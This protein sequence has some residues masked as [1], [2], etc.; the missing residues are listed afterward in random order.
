MVGI[1]HS[2][3]DPDI[4]NDKI[5]P[6]VR[7]DT[8]TFFRVEWSG[9]VTPLAQICGDLPACQ[10]TLDNMC[11]CDVDV[12]ETQVFVAVPNRDDVLRM[13]H[14]GAFEPSGAATGSLNGV[15]WYNSN[16]ST[17]LSKD[18]I[19]A[20]VD[21]NGVRRLR[22]NMKSTANIAGTNMEFRNPVH[23]MS[24]TEPE[25]RDAQHETDA[26]LDHYFYHPN[27]GPFL[28]LRF[29]QRFGISNPSP[30]YIEAMANAFR[31]GRY[32]VGS[33][34]FGSG[35][36]GDL[37][38]M[39]A[40]VVLDREARTPLLDADPSFGSLREPLLKYM[41]LMRSMDFR[42]TKDVLVDFT[43]AVGA[44][45]GQM[46]HDIPSVFSFFLPEYSLQGPIDRASLVAPEGQVLT[47]TRIV[48]S[49]NA[50][51]SLIKY[52]LSQCWGGFRS[53]TYMYHSL[54]N[55]HNNLFCAFA[56]D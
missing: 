20:F 11:L 2:P 45:I 46:A 8:Q 43:W 9:K 13:L 55:T 33:V 16:G 42:K 31:T 3:V 17:E 19:F 30:R 53:C 26:A 40:C 52:G 7:N 49:L 36:Y 12:S 22:K 24:F 54:C 50:Y 48:D 14:I 18:T 38:A 41:G 1:V 4:T 44:K 37:G 47:S 25:L 6:L 56:G 29:A 23:F 10:V 51:L 35:T 34:S 5:N 15:T 39:V 27:T 21:D 32:S 28:A